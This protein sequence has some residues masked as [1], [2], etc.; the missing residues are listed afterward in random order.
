MVCVVSRW[1]LAFGSEEGSSGTE[2]TG[3]KA[4]HV[5]IVDAQYTRGKQ[6]WGIIN[7]PGYLNF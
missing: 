5:V 4:E 7:V 6:V 2:R 3:D 1:R